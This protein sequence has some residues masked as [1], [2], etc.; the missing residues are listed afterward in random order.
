MSSISAGTT[1]GTA[2]VSTGDTSGNLVLQTNGGTSA[3][4]LNTAQAIGVGSSPSFGT[5]GQAL[6]SNGNTAPPGWGTLGAASGGTGLTSPGTAGNVLTSNG[7]AWVSSAPTSAGSGGTTATG[8]VT[9]TNTSPGAQSVTPAGFGGFVK[10]PDATTMTKA[11]INFNIRNAGDFPLKIIDNA[12]NILGFIYPKMSASVGCADNSTAAGVWVVE[13]TEPIGYVMSYLNTSIRYVA[14]CACFALDDSRQF[15]L[16]QEFST[17]S[18]YAVVYDSNTG[19]FGSATLVASSA[20]GTGTLAAAIKMTANSV[21]VA[22]TS[23]GAIGRVL[24]ISGTTITVNAASSAATSTANVN[25]PSLTLIGSTYIFD[26]TPGANLN[27]YLHAITVSGTTVTVGTEV[28]AS[29]GIATINTSPGVPTVYQVTSSSFLRLSVYGSV[30]VYAQA[31]SISGTTITAG[32]LLTIA[33]TSGYNTY[34]KTFAVGSQW[35]IVYA[36]SSNQPSCSIISVSGTTCSAS[37]VNAVTG[38]ITNAQSMDAVV[39]GNKIIFGC[40]TGSA[41]YNIEFNI[42]T[43]SSGTASKGT[44]ITDSNNGVN[45]YN[46]IRSLTA[47]NNIA[48]FGVQGSILSTNVFVMYCINFSG[49]SPTWSAS[50]RFN[51]A[52]PNGTSYNSNI[53]PLR[54]QFSRAGGLVGSSSSPMTGTLYSFNTKINQNNGSPLFVTYGQNFDTPYSSFAPAAGSG[55]WTSGISNNENWWITSFNPNTGGTIIGTIAYKVECVTV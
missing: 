18:L 20:G 46:N 35:A 1:T 16:W 52:L 14:P 9:L 33:T 41:P 10:L 45:G 53:I 19:A 34:A 39:S 28:T 22:Y 50:P 40:V 4:T 11:A 2:L 37:T 13:G 47:S 24:S 42:V 25:Y 49:S 15:L 38:S 32:S 3:L 27:S 5:S 23:A 26:K 17:T 21:L 7:S 36:D 6:I 12:S 43:N 8:N 48:T 54:N 44:Q 31:F 55:T 30:A 29:G 51:N